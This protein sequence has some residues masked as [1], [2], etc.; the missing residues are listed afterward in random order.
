M[1]VTTPSPV[2]STYFYTHSKIYFLRHER[3][4]Y[5]P[6]TRYRGLVFRGSVYDF[7]NAFGMKVKNSQGIL[8][9]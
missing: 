7:S 8:T 5:K 1:Q 9:I 2:V 3:E 4:G 6:I